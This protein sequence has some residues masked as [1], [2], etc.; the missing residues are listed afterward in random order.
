MVASPDLRH[1]LCPSC[2]ADNLQDVWEV[3]PWYRCQACGAPYI[4]GSVPNDPMA[5]DTLPFIGPERF[6]ARDGE[7]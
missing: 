5:W 6:G 1:F 3:A 2:E 4:V 7:G